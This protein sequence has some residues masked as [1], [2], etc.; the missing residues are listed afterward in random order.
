M[1]NQE[2]Q[3]L[4]K[5]LKGLCSVVEQQQVKRLLDTETGKTMLNNIM[6]ERDLEA[7]NYEMPDEDESG[8]DH[9]VEYWKKE[10]S[11]RMIPV[12][13]NM[14]QKV[15]KLYF[16][17]HV[18]IWIGAFIT[19]GIAGLMI[20]KIIS[21]SK[22]A[23]IKKENHKGIPVRYILPDSSI[24][25]LA[26]GGSL[27]YDEDYP[28][29]GRDVHLSGAAFFDVKHDKAHPF[30]IHTDSVETRVLGTSFKISAFKGEP[31]EVAVAT[32]KVR[33]STSKGKMMLATL[34]PGRKVS[35]NIGTGKTEI[36]SVDIEGLEQW[37]MGELIFD[38]QP[39]KTIVK[40]LKRRYGTTVIL[41]DDSIS[42]YRVSGTFS[43]TDSV[44]TVLKMLSILGKFSYKMQDRNIYYLS[45]RKNM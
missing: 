1:E 13:N 10:V 7:G 14:D 33:V 37:K 18:A 22:I 41:R 35:Y 26:A 4:Q 12:K 27:S 28:N 42:D 20:G 3:L 36:N 43:A 31:L 16:L 38:D 29:S 17:R 23:S 19:V 9:R 15:R 32:G 2:Q 30:T 44:E 5:F 40:E 25:Y 24:V 45:K 39:L 6:E 8:L 11:A 21:T 34:T